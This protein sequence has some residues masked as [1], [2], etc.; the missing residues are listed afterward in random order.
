MLFLGEIVKI[1]LS[2]SAACVGALILMTFLSLWRL[3]QNAQGVVWAEDGAVFLTDALA[4]DQAFTPLRPYSGY[5]HL[6]PRLAAGFVVRFLRLEHFGIGLTVL[7]CLAV[8][9]ICLLTYHCASGISNNRW[10]RAAWGA[11]P[12]VVNVGAMETLGN[13][14]N[15]HWYLL[16][17]A[18]WLLM[19]PAKS[20]LEGGLLFVVAA[21]TSLTEIISVVFVPLFLYK[22]RHKN[23]WPAR[24]GLGLGLACQAYAT[25]RRPRGAAG[26]YDLDPLSVVYGWFLNT[27]G[28][29]VHGSPAKVMQQIVNF[30]AAPMI[31]AAL[32]VLAGIA[33]VLILGTRSEKWLAVF[34]ATASVVIWAACVLSNPAQ[35]L[36]YATFSTADWKQFFVFGRYSVAPTMFVLAIVPLLASAVAKFGKTAPFAV[37]TGFSLLAVSMYFPGTTATDN[38]PDWAEHVS[39]GRDLCGTVPE[40]EFYDIP[41]SPTFFEGRVRIPCDVLRAP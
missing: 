39:I 31:V 17:L 15:L 26:H 27:A 32:V 19:K 20:K 35:Y 21:L 11:I 7:A 4:P 10:I 25:L 23:M 40:T 9:G 12:L 5:L 2:K 1:A 3:P 18:P 13:F 34:F 41:T 16:W 37:L 29:I 6:V 38:G 33:A 24:A 8:A 36:D 30:G 28:P 22:I 14:A